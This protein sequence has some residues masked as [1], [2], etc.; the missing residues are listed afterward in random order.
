MTRSKQHRQ[1]LVQLNHA[2]SSA[3]RPTSR[4]ISKEDDGENPTGQKSRKRTRDEIQT[5]DESCAED[6][7]EPEPKRSVSF[8]LRYSEL[9]SQI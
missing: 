1:V 6:V 5:Q 8:Y 9:I 4:P 3:N 7:E 2:V